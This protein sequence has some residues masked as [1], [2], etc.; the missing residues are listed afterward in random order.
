MS[1]LE[2]RHRIALE[3]KDAERAI[4]QQRFNGLNTLHRTNKA[5][6]DEKVLQQGKLQNDMKILKRE[7]AA[8]KAK[9]CVVD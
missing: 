9:K 6:I 2:N 3:A 1:E 7:L 8:E 5:R 4:L